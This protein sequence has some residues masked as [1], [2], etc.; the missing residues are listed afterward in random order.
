M[1][2]I[3]WPFFSFTVALLVACGGGG[4]SI[5]PVPEEAGNG[6]KTAPG[7]LYVGYY[8]EDVSTNPEDPT[9]GAIYLNLPV[10][11]A[12]FAGDMS[13][14]FVGCQSFNVG[15][16]RGEKSSLDLSGTWTGSVDGRAQNGQFVGRFNSATST[17]VGTYNNFL[18]K[19][20]VRVDDCIEYFIAPNGRWELF[21]VGQTAVGPTSSLTATG[22]L[23][24][25]NQITWF[26]PAGSSAGSVLSI[27]DPSIAVS[28][29]SN[30]IIW[31]NLYNAGITTAT[32]PSTVVLRPGQ[33]YVATASTVGDTSLE[34][35]SSK[36]FSIP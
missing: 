32:L 6:V 5:D 22:V 31:Q 35:F 8:R 12:S 19:Q 2:F 28:G 16:I 34:Y 9:T 26:P 15:T 23:I 21:P 27:L 20:F 29:G 17:Y 1:K 18:G 36:K 10:G 13:F 25:G 33:E 7:G 24:E 3:K 4:S 30:A 14:T 11:D